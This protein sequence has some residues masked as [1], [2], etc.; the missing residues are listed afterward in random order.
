MKRFSTIALLLLCLAAMFAPRGAAAQSACDPFL[1]P[2]LAAHPTA[3]N[4]LKPLPVVIAGGTLAGELLYLLLE[5]RL[6]NEGYAVQFFPL[7]QGGTI[8]IPTGAGTLACVVDEVLARTGA[9]K[10]H[11]IGHSQG[12]LMGRTYIKYW[13]AEDK[14]E[15][16]ISLAGPHQGTEVVSGSFLQYPLPSLLGCF[17]G[18][19][20]APCQ[21]MA[22]NSPLIQDVNDRPANDPIY[23]TNFV[24]TDDAWVIPYTNGFMPYDCDKTSAQGQLLKCNVHIQAYCPNLLLPPDHVTLPSDLNVWYGIR[25]ALLHQ[26]IDLGCGLPQS[27]PTNLE[28]E[29]TELRFPLERHRQLP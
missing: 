24:T 8:D 22:E 6:R 25:T 29:S 27:N 20:S 19:L 16:M 17:G 15:S 18:A 11:L 7:P 9:A 23:Y 10:V 21:Q 28:C 26:P 14:V 3:G 5:E 4:S 12:A 13:N 1:P 2:F